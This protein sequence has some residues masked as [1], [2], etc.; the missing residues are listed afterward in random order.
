MNKD[1]I[2][3]NGKTVGQVE[4]EM[5]LA[6]EQIYRDNWASQTCFTKYTTL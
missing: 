4:A 3:P 6:V 1:T 2:L 5:R